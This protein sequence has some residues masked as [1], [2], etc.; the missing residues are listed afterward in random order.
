MFV[1]VKLSRATRRGR[2]ARVDMRC[3]RGAG[4]SPW[5]LSQPNTRAREISGGAVELPSGDSSLDDDE[6]D[7]DEEDEESIVGG[8][9][10]SAL[11]ASARNLGA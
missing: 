8:L 11:G 10:V 2:R 4:L 1:S 7:D 6:G 5:P 3:M 9:I